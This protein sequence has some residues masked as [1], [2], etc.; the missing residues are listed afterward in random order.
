MSNSALKKIIRDLQPKITKDVN[1]DH[2][3]DVLFCKTILSEED[4]YTLR[5]V[6][7]SRNRCRQLLSLLHLSS[8]PETFVEFRLALV[9]EYWWIV[10]EIDKKLELLSD[11][12][13]QHLKHSK[14]LC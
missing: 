9:N 11:E 8:R 14:R 1:P 12:P 6:P 4:N 10:E 2:M 3:I 5:Q 13:Q 7:D